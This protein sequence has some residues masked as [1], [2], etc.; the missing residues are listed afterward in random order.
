[1]RDLSETAIKIKVVNDVALIDEVD[2][3]ADLASRARFLYGARAEDDGDTT[4]PASQASPA[5]ISFSATDR[6]GTRMPKVAVL[7]LAVIALSGCGAAK[8]ARDTGQLFDKYGC[9]ARELKGE[10]PCQPEGI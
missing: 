2:C 8:A 3:T 1:V 7:L 5:G 10:T 6:R 4:R 9:M